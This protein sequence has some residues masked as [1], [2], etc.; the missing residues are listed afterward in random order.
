MDNPAPLT[1]Y[2]NS[3]ADLF[4]LPRPPVVTAAEAQKVLSPTLLSYL[5][6]SH[7]MDN[8]PMLKELG[9][10]MHYPDLGSD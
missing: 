3:I 9:L 2:F 8:R 1:Q 10:K 5:N 4:C 7:R 6:E